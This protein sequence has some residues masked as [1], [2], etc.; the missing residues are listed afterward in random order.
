MPYT[1][2]YFYWIKVFKEEHINNKVH[3]TRS[4][5]LICEVLL[6]KEY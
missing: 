5:Y 2:Y 6:Y 4:S 1:N 3:G